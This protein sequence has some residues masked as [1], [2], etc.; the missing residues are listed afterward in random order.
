MWSGFGCQLKPSPF[1]MPD[2]E[3]PAGLSVAWVDFWYIQRA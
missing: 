2:E 3:G 1:E